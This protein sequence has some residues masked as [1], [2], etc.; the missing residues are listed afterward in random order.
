MVAGLKVLTSGSGLV[1][2]ETKRGAIESE[3]A[4]AV[5]TRAA[6]TSLSLIVALAASAMVV[7]LAVMLAEERR[8]R[9]AVLR[10]L[11]LTRAGLVK[12]AV[13]EG[14]IYSLGGAIAGLPLGLAVGMVLNSDLQP[15]FNGSTGGGIV[16]VLSPSSLLGSVAAAA[17]I[18]LTTLFITS[19]QTS[20]MA[21]SAA[22]RDLPEPTRT[23][24]IPWIRLA[25]LAGGALI[26]AGL[27]V[28]AGPALHVVG[29]ALVIAC[30]GGLIRGRL[31]DRLRYTVIGAAMATWAVGYTSLTVQTWGTDNQV[32]ASMM[33][34]AVTVAGLSVLVASNLR[35][36]E[37]IVRLPGRVAS[38]VRATLRPALAYT[39]RRPLRSGLVIGAIGLIVA[40]LT[41]L[42]ASVSANRPNY[43]RD[44]GG[45]DVRVTEVGS[46]Q[47]ALPA[48]V[49]R[50]I[51]REEMLASRTF[52][53]PIKWNSSGLGPNGDWQQQAVNIF[54]LTDAQLAAGVVPLVSWDPK[55]HSATEVW[56]AIANDP[57][58]VAGPYLSSTEVRLAT[59][60]GTLHLTVVALEGSLGTA[61]SIVDGLVGSQSLLDRLPDSTPG[62]VLLLQAASGV[63]PRALA[64]QVQRATLA[65]GADATTTTQILDDGYAQGRGFIDL[66][67]ALMRVGLLV[68]VFS[69]GTI[70]LRAV[71]ERRRAI[72]VLRAIGFRPGQVLLGIVLETILTATAGLAVGLGAAYA[73]GSSTLVGGV[74]YAAFAPDAWTLWSAIGLVYAAV[75]L[76][77]LLP[78][79]RAARLRPAE[80]LRVVG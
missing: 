67:L 35:L 57:T 36:L 24:G 63:T 53:G 60:Q 29:G 12:V 44:S 42:S 30:A 76:V 11:G 10:A 58:L 3:K 40:I 65:K 34:L 17:L 48:E 79:I 80:A 70:A 64:D 45:F 2:L 4:Q 7:N 69:L 56:K 50:N 47:L 5:G 46:G 13:V 26:G 37:S 59:A 19:L 74:I 72:G 15:A 49:Q 78:A 41:S 73:V 62:V 71:V 43:V 16:L 77:T 61:P 39:S 75:L 1:V 55:Y 22:I 33:G 38:D 18:T 21:I 31:S 14:A 51:R 9:L 28:A 20:R 68:G 8:P 32:P 52:L 27:V 25:L 23:R 6:F 54:G 66:L